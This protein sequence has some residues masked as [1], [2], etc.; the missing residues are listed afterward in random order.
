MLQTSRLSL[1]NLCPGDIN[2]LYDYRNDSKCN[3]YQR[4]EDTSR[5]YLHA[6]V[7]E[8]SRST[9]LSREE[10]QHYAIIRSETG[11]MIGDLSVFY[12]EKDNCFTFGI[13]IAPLFQHHGYAY[14]LLSEVTAQFQ[15]R[16]PAV[17]L[18]ALIEKGNIPSISLFQK[19]GFMEECYA[20]SI[21][22]YVFVIYG[23]EE[24]S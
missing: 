24:Q 15:Q 3:L 4:Y 19:L 9:F 6:F 23:K 18:V 21:Q 22:S 5:E 2:T 16:Y 20:E 1:R 12:T 7:R 17:D 11:E 10:E 13:T 14:E 8:Y